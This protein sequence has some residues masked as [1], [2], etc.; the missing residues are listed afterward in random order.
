MNSVIA[1]FVILTDGV[2]HI[3]ENLIESE[4]ELKFSADILA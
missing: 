4:I 3:V 2:F 1:S